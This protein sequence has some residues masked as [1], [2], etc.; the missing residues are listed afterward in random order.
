MGKDIQDYLDKGLYGAPQLKPDEQRKYLGTYRER[1]VF[2]LTLSELANSSYE[3]F[4]TNQFQQYEHGT[5]LVNALVKPNLQKKLITL[6]Q[7]NHV[8]LKLVDTDHTQLSDDAIAVVYALDHAVNKSNINLP[9]Q[10][11]SKQQSASEK[12][13]TDRKKSQGFFKS[14]FTKK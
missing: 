4:A 11:K 10:T 5:L 1:V 12:Q 13:L 6:T 8:L 14:L 3:S 2:V 7:N 9:L